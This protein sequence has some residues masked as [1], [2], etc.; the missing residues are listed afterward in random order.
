MRRARIGTVLLAAWIVAGGGAC[1]DG[2]WPVWGAAEAQ[3]ADGANDAP[4]DPFRTPLSSSLSTPADRSTIVEL[5]FDV[6]R[7]DLPHD[8]VRHSAKLWNHVDELR[9]E[10]GQSVLLGRNGIRVGVAPADAWPAM[11]AVLE[12]HGAR[13]TRRQHAVQPGYPLTLDIGD[14]REGETVFS[15]DGQGG[16]KGRTFGAGQK[17]IHLDYVVEADDPPRVLLRVTPDVHVRS[18][19]RRWQEEEEGAY[20]EKPVDGGHSYTELSAAVSLT[21]GQILVIGPGPQAEMAHLLGNRFFERIEAGVRY[22]T[23]YFATPQLFR[24]ETPE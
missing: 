10:P 6:M 17:Y 8:S 2:R 20:V 22:E 4:P 13:A 24:S 15:Y 11:Q 14:V 5:H 16:L 7:V 18:A 19:D 21:P 12:A 9:V 3:K 23:L 1:Q